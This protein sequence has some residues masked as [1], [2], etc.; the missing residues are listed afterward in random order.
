MELRIFEFIGKTADYI[1]N[2]RDELEA[3]QLE[4][5]LYFMQIL[6]GC[7]E[8]FLNISSRIKGTAS[9]KEKIIR[10]SY[11]KNYDEPQQLI[12]NLSDLIGIRLE[13]RFIDD[14][15][16]LYKLLLKYF[17]KINE[18]GYYYNQFNPAISLA[19]A[20]KQPQTQ[21]NGFTIYKI[22]GLYQ[23][24]GRRLRFE[25]QIKSLVNLFW[26]EIEHKIIYK[27]DT[28]MLADGF[29][30]DIM[31]TVKNIF[32]MLDNQLLILYKRFNSGTTI[33]P[34]QQRENIRTLLSKSIFDIFAHKMRQ[35][36]GFIV[37][38]RSSCDLI[39]DYILMKSNVEDTNSYNALMVDLLERLQAI[40]ARQIEFNSEITFER[41]YQLAN[42]LEKRLGDTISSLINV[43]YRWHLFFTILFE[44][45]PGN[46]VEDFENFITFLTQLFAASRPFHKLHKLFHE[47]LARDMESSLLMK[48]ADCFEAYQNIDFI[49]QDR[50]DMIQKV[51]SDIVKF[52]CMSVRTEKEWQACRTIFLD[53]FALRLGVMLDMKTDTALLEECVNAIEASILRPRIRLHLLDYIM[54]N[55]TT[56]DGVVRHL[57]KK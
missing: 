23:K 16:R 30:K 7:D 4:L 13:C 6:T 3:I 15:Y 1:E 40:A 42:P 41:P 18:D 52:I 46:N 8:G 54:E 9:L 48:M 20:E 12:D 29:L 25:L 44:L 5:E 45:E 47:N 39:I 2:M 26:S 50:I 34:S 17:T 14:E 10:N 37:E 49:H 36:I 19:L 53:M 57:D 27:N 31:V 22:D 51:F 56:M 32:T 21:R 38:F 28:Y 55:V 35:D 24:N 11:Y 43:D 33:G